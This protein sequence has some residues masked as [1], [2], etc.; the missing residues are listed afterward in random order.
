MEFLSLSQLLTV[1]LDS[2]PDGPTSK[3]ALTLS[4]L[5]EQLRRTTT[6]A[7]QVLHDYGMSPEAGKCQKLKWDNVPTS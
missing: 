1:Y 2:T 5:R 3:Y 6:A 4:T 7:I